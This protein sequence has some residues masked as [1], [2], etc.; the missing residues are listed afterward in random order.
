MSSWID[1]YKPGE[2]NDFRDLW[3]RCMRE[4]RECDVLILYREKD[5]ILRGA[6]LECG[7]ALAMGQDVFAIGC[8]DYGTFIHHPLVTVYGSVEE[9]LGLT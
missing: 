8:E 9:A 2:T 6:L 3:R 1:E 5:E 4:A 7:A